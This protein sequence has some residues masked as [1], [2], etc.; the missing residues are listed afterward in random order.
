MTRAIVIFYIT[1]FALGAIG[2]AL[3]PHRPGRWTKF[4]TY[5]VI[6]ATVIAARGAREFYAVR[7]KLPFAVWIVYATVSAGALLFALSAAPRRGLRL[8]DPR[9]LRRFQSDLGTTL[10]TSSARSAD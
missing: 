1:A 8:P 2:M 6:T 10:R 3:A 5:F 7:Q 4:A 9:R